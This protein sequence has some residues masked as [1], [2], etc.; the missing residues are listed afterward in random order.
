MPRAQSGYSIAEHNAE[1]CRA[2]SGSSIAEHNA[3]QGVGI[4]APHGTEGPVER[5][6]AFTPAHA[7]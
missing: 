1:I 7:K 6:K 4:L 2:Q 5:H 3:A